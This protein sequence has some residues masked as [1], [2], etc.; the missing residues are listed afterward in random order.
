VEDEKTL[1]NDLARIIARAKE[2]FDDPEIAARLARRDRDDKARLEASEEE[3]IRGLAAVQKAWL[4]GLGVPLSEAEVVLSGVQPRGAVQKLALLSLRPV[5]VLAGN[6]G[7]GKTCAA[8]QHLLTC[9]GPTRER[10]QCETAAFVT[11]VDF[12][13][14]WPRLREDRLR[15]AELE[16][17]SAL[18]IDDLGMEEEDLTAR[19]DH[20]IYQRAG[21]R[22]QTVLTV[23]MKAEE[24]RRRYDER[25]W[26]RLAQ[27]GNFEELPDPDYRAL[28]RRGAAASID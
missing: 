21:N 17:C 14:L 26:S 16:R 4:L 2:S 27:S 13:R 28:G 25:I 23:N 24:F 12:G 19:L 5:L 11:A 3:R 1:A 18:C 10:C 22:R 6:A 9:A 7:A 15:L 20:L 8:V